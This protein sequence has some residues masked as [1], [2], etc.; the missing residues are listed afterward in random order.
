MKINWY[1]GHMAAAKRMLEQN[2][3]IIDIVLLLLD[4][5]VPASGKNPDLDRLAAGKQQ[6]VVLNK[7]DLADPVQTAKWLAEY[8][9]RGIAAMETS[10]TKNKRAELLANLDKL[11]APARERAAQRGMNKTARVLVCGI[12]NVGK[13]TLINTLAG[14]ARAKTGNKPGVTRGKQWIRVHDRLELL[15]SPGLLWPKLED[16]QAAA[17]LAYIGTINDE[18]LDKEELAL[19]LLAE[20]M[21]KY[22]QLLCERYRIERPETP[23]SA[24]EAICRRRGL[25]LKGG[26]P[27]YLRCA[28]MLLDELRSGK[29]GRIT[30]DWADKL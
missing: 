5:R 15:D 9:S 14:S 30:L 3:K 18:T 4:A 6:L 2:L 28:G 24:Y 10:L 23:L 27:D 20:L 25:L 19:L 21:E 12:P 16:Q 8:K 7:A 13:S 1:P 11:A 22:P 29:L 26:E 17:R